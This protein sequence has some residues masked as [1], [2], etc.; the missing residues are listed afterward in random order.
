CG[1]LDDSSVAA[2]GTAGA[3]CRLRLSGNADPWTEVAGVNQD[4]GIFASVNGG[5]DQ[6]LAWKE[7]GGFAGTFSPNAAT[8][9]AVY[10]IGPGNT[11]RFSL[12]W[13]TNRP[14]PP[15]VRIHA[16]AGAWGATYSS[17]SMLA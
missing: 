9:H 6:L 11:Y 10:S 7:S 5:A 3:S 14:A 8:V 15:S 13:K 17:T 1:L 2:P 16:G 12:K 4:L